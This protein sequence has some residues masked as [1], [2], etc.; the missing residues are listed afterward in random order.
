[1][2]EEGASVAPLVH[3]AAELFEQLADEE[4]VSVEPAGLVAA[5]AEAWGASNGV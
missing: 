1:M 4:A 3:R 5:F 2:T